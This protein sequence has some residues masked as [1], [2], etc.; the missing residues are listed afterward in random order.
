MSLIYVNP[1]EAMLKQQGVL[2]VDGASGSE[3]ESKGHD[4]NDALWSAQLLME[5]PEAILALHHEYLQAGAD[6]ITTVSYQA[7]VQGF[8]KR[9]LSEN[10]SNSLLQLSVQLALQ[11]RDEFWADDT[12]RVG[13]VKPIVAASIGPYGA[14]LADGSEYRGDYGLDEMALIDFHHKRMA[15]II[16]AKPDIIACETVPCLIE[17]KALVTVL[18]S[19]PETSAWICFS[20]K[21]AI[22]TNNGETL[23][24]CAQYLDKQTQVAAIGINCTAPQY[25]A[26]LI[27]EIKAVTHKAIIVYPNGGGSY[28][29]VTKTWSTDT[30]PDSYSEMA[31]HW[32]ETGATMIGGC[33]QTRPSDIAGIAHWAREL[34]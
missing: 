11:A 14:Y 2:V 33:C 1:V 6:C 32:Y 15:T 12:N 34:E 19:F 8:M 20:A 21:D 23:R 26:S 22:H 29:A 24:S 25:A 30:K 3:L 4:I 16:A 9:G 18:K 27:Q 7:T 17:A 10:Q 28:D 5:K 31:K 13:R